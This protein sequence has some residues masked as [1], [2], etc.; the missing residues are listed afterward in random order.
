[1]AAATPEDD[2][3]AA[4]RLAAGSFQQADPL[5]PGTL[6]P[7]AAPEA[8]SASSGEG[9][10]L[11]E[12]AAPGCFYEPILVGSVE[13]LSRLPGCDD[14][15][16]LVIVECG[17]E[18]RVRPPRRAHSQPSFRCEAGRTR[19]GTYL[20]PCRQRVADSAPPD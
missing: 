14:S 2:F 16:H 8:S 19:L 17:E 12:S 3:A 4:S 11:W 15:Q 13:E 10:A 6:A 20:S 18:W 1:M 5:S 9:S 7:S